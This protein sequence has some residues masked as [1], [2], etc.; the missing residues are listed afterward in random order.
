MSMDIKQLIVVGLVGVGTALLTGKTFRRILLLPF[1]WISRKTHS[2]VDDKLVDEARR[3]LGV[4]DP[5]LEEH[6]NDER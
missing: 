6:K 4:P 5:T 1:E 3:D 2:K